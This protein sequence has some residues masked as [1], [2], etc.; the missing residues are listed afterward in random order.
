MASRENGA[1]FDVVERRGYRGYLAEK[2]RPGQVEA[3]LQA[4]ELW[5]TRR[6]IFDDDNEGFRQTEA[7]LNRVIG[8]VGRD[9]ACHLVFSEERA[10]WESRNR[11]AQIQK[12]RQ[13]RLGLGW[14]NHD[15]H[16]FRCSRSHFVDLMRA[17]GEHA[18]WTSAATH[19]VLP[20]LATDAGIALQVQTGVA[21]HRSPDSPRRSTASRSPTCCKASKI[22]S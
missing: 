22:W 3:L 11:A 17:L 16:T 21:S 15:H 12:R 4:H 18:S 1:R 14:S 2:T 7:V 10:Y 8:L 5:K 20:L 13:N 6:R 9:R 19:P